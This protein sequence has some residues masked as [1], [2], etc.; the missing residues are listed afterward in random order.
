MSPPTIKA[1]KTFHAPSVRCGC[2]GL[3]QGVQCVSQ[4][5][6]TRLHVLTWWAA[7]SQAALMPAAMFSN[8]RSLFSR[9]RTGEHGGVGSTRG[10]LEN[11][12]VQEGQQLALPWSQASIISIVWDLLGP[13]LLQRMNG[14]FPLTSCSTRVWRC[15]SSLL[16]GCQ[17]VS[18]APSMDEV[19]RGK[20]RV[21]Q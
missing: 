7:L 5:C 19:L 2:R 14:L 8:H 18:T 9:R 17:S 3:H 1:A 12:R 10:W 11:S 20:I 16:H 6:S 4:T 13:L 21:Q 15:V